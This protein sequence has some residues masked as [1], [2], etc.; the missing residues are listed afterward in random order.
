M[1]RI[2]LI[3]MM[4]IVA[5]MSSLSAF[6]QNRVA[7]TQN[8]YALNGDSVYVDLK[9]EL[10]NAEVSPRAFVLLTPVIQTENKTLELP[11]VMINGKNRHK[12]YLRMVS[13][14][15]EPEGVES[16]ISVD[17]KDAQQ[18]RYY[19]VAV[20]Y[21]EWMEDADFAIREDQCDCNGPL[22][23]MSFNLITG[24]MQ[25]QNPIIEPE[26]NFAASFIKPQPEPIKHRSETGKAYL[27]FTIGKSNLDPVLKNN[28]SEL[29]RIGSMIMKVKNDPSVTITRVIIDG[30]AS[31]D[32]ASNTNLT[33]SEKR[34][35]ALKDYVSTTYDLDRHLIKVTGHG[36]DWKMMEKLVASLNVAWKEQALEIIRS[37][38]DLDTR[39]RNLKVLQGGAV[40]KELTAN[41][42]TKLRRSDYELQYTVIPFTVAEGKNKLETNPSL[43]S[44]NEMYLI[45]QTY[46]VGSKEFQRVFEIAVKTFPDD[47]TANFNAAA[48]ALEKGDLEAAV[49]YMDKVYSNE[50]HWENN[51]GIIAAMQRRYDIASVHFAKAAI[52]NIPEAF[53]NL[54]EMNKVK[55]QALKIQKDTNTLSKI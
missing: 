3:Q 22:V 44:L 32:G 52:G 51:M 7:I 14:G 5:L 40:W 4:T 18:P 39:E 17:D 38:D 34:A 16:V 26:L 15:R 19:S 8:R 29:S 43:L 10:N 12:T 48:T 2:Q 33:L 45:A 13:M 23:K 41:V 21:E 1:Q 47:M 55:Q 27:D 35:A 30:W 42:L 50:P 24:K 36:E 53:K 6:S 25:N 49:K 11:A 46:P 20:P 54:E 9:I 28:A 31:P 37:K